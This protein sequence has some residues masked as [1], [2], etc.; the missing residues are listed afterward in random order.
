M[1]IDMPTRTGGPHRGPTPPLGRL[2]LI[3][4]AAAVALAACG[5]AEVGGTTTPGG[6]T[7]PPE[8]TVPSTSEAPMGDGPYGIADI[9]VVIEHPERDT[10]TYRISCLVDTATVQG[11]S[12]EVDEQEACATLSEEAAITRLVE[13]P[14]ED[15][16]CTEIYGGPDVATITGTIDEAAVDAT[17][18]RANGCGISDWDDLLGG[19]LPPAV[20]EVASEADTAGGY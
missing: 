16:M 1:T 9:E 10:L 11:D 20:G 6:E 3:T 8:E 7:L 13:G 5:G 18:D 19:M 4:V 17:V 2:A 15:Q 14:P 12:V